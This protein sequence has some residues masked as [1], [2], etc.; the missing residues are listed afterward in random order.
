ML[1]D[2]LDDGDP[3]LARNGEVK[4]IPIKAKELATI[5]TNISDK[6][7]LMRG[8]A[9]SRVERVSV[10]DKLEQIAGKLEEHGKLIESA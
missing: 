2:I 10:S 6:R 7:S 3:V 9:T 1:V 4:Y 8:H 5:I